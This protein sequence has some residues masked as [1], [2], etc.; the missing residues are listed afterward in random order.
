MPNFKP[1]LVIYHDQ[2]ADGFGAAWACWQ[3]WGDACE[4]V[5]ANYGQTPPDV[6]GRHVL[7]VDF[8]YKN[9]VLQEMARAARSIV[10]L[11]HHKTAREDLE[12]FARFEGKPERF[13]PAVV[14]LMV[15]DLTKGGYPPIVACFDMERSG[16]RM[17]WE[18]CHERPAPYLITLIEDRDLW[19]F[20]L[21]DTKPF[22][23]WLRAEPFSFARFDEIAHDL[24][25]TTTCRTIMREAAAMQR[26]FDAK[27][28]EI[29][30]FARRQR[31]GTFEPIAVNCPPMF[32]SE[33]GHA[34]LDAHPGAPFAATYFDGANARMW[35]LRSRDDREDVS[36]IAAKFGGGG[37][38][39]A[40][41]FSVPR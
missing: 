16:A 2:C 21:P 22:G 41:G 25:Y 36:A 7:I 12:Q 13:T 30:S 4:Y 38:R 27:V 28:Q 6:T 17:A 35:S 3:R 24:A 33:V 18:F 11:D 40:A 1:D 23:L 32:A 39:N 31:V 9:A 26:F 37:H 5:A 19:R 20:T 29:A 34:L 8:S 10:V 15:G 14:G